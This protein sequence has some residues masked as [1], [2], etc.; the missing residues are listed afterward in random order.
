VT[1]PR[2]FADLRGFFFVAIAIESTHKLL[3]G[4]WAWLLQRLIEPN[5]KFENLVGPKHF[6][7]LAGSTFGLVALDC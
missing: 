4:S 5:F 3:M 6:L 2:K 1:K 7:D